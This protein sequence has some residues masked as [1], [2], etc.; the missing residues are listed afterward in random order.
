MPGT[1]VPVTFG[2]ST[3][4]T[5]QPGEKFWSDPVM[6][7]LPD[8]DDL[9]FT[10]AVSAQATGPTMPATSAPFLT[11]F[12][13]NGKNLAGQES[14]AG[15]SASYDM[16]VAPQMFASDRPITKRLCFLGDSITQGIGSTRDMYSYWVA[17]IA[18]GLGPDQSAS[19][20]WAAA[21][22]ARRTPPPTDSGC[23]R[24]SSATRSP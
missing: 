3:T 16:L 14:N 19:G 13:A 15:F 7:D 4:K 1:L 5:V 8:G 11:T 6:L 9:V 17:K 23:G 12:F 21:G 2:G 22:R 20:T 24:R 18:D 10:W